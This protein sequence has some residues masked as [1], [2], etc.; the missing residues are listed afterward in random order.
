MVQTMIRTLFGYNQWAHERL[1]ECLLTLDE[2]QFTRAFD[3]S[4]GSVRNQIV[5]VM[6]VDN[7]WLHRVADQPVPVHFQPE[8]YPS[9]AA[10]R[11]EWEP[12]AAAQ[13][14]IVDGLSDAQL[15]ERITYDMPKYGGL[16]HTA[17]WE[18]LAHVVNHGTDHRAQILSLLYQ[19][20]APTV[21]QDLIYY[22][23]AI[24]AQ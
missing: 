22:L 6:S 8:A 15:A 12:L 13:R 14:A 3:Y 9:P 19:L 23:W 1:W 2:A 5:H 18:V 20:G 24:N 21:E 17:R 10:V 7:R 11:A 4:I 16:K